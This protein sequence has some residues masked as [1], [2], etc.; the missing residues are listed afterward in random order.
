MGEFTPTT[1][2]AYIPE[3]WSAKV[4][5]YAYEDVLLADLVVSLDSEVA[6]FGDIV[7]MPVMAVLSTT[8][9]SADTDV[10]FTPIPI[11]MRR[12]PSIRTN[13]WQ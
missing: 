5:E 1:A 8:T 3:V 2:S 7:H 13:T 12:S 6:S 4:F 10:T 11:R 9:K